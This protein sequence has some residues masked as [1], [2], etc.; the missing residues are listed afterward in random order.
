MSQSTAPVRERPGGYR[1]SSNGLI[2]AMIATVAAVLLFVGVRGLVGGDPATPVQTVDWKI[3]FVA[4]RSEG[5]LQV[6]APAA[7]PAGWRATSASYTPEPAPDWHLGVL[8]SDTKYVGIDETRD[9]LQTLV[10]HTIDKNA[11]PG[12][13]VTIAGKS[14]HVFTDAGGDYALGRTIDLGGGESESQLVG[15]SAKPETIR[16]FVATLK[17]GR[18]HPGQ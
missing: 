8:T 5:R 10:Q 7:L 15:G 14:W 9:D 18:V 16:A 13:E 17:A 1:R 12:G 11:S 6:L 2:G 4:G 3:S